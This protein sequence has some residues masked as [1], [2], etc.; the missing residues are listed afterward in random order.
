MRTPAREVE[1][2]LSCTR[3]DRL[4][5]NVTG[6]DT[7]TASFGVVNAGDR[8][9]SDVPQLYLTDAPDGHACGCWDSNG[10]SWNRGRAAG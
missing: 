7:V 9:G 6:G 8:A 5:L 1:A 4:D 3:F 2:Q 10:S